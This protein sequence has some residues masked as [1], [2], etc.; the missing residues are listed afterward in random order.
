MAMKR[1]QEILGEETKREQ[2]EAKKYHME[3]DISG[4]FDC[5]DK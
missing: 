5:Y 3:V 2:S 1:P 4:K